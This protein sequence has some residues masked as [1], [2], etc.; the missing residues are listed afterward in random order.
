MNSDLLF[1]LDRQVNVFSLF[2]KNSFCLFVRIVLTTMT[3][4]RFK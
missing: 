3:Y 4:D 2:F 1:V